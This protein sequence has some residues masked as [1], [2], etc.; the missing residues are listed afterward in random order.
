MP[1]IRCERCGA[2][3]YVAAANVTLPECAGC[4]HQ[5]SVTRTALL[6]PVIAYSSRRRA[7]SRPQPDDGRA[8]VRNHGRRAAVP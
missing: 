4:G 7:K 5:I 2:S 8:G 3:Q 6:A 1:V